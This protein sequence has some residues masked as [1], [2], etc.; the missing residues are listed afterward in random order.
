VTYT[1]T[2]RNVSDVLVTI[3]NVVDDRFG[4]LDDSGGNGCFDVPINLAPGASTF[5]QF[6]GTVSG[7]AGTTHVNVVTATG[8]DA[9]D[10]P[11][12]GSDDARVEITPRLIDLVIDK[13]ATSPTPLNGTV[14]YTL[15]VT[16]RGPD[17]A[18]NVQLAD[19]A[20]A[21]VQYQSASTSQGTCAVTPALVTCNLGTIA[22]GQVVTVTVTG[23]ATATGTHVNTATVSG[24]GGRETNPADN[25]DS[26]QTVVPA[27][28]RPPTK[29]TKPSK[30]K[31]PAVEADVCLALTVSPSSVTADGK[32]DRVRTLVTAGTKRMKGVRVVIRGVGIAKT[33]RTNERGVAV[34]TINPRRAGIITITAQE[35]NRQICG[36]K[37][38]GAVGV[39]LPPVTG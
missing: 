38:I 3:E 17:Q 37:R 36:P 2:I 22:P 8:K 26:A 11:V 20:P 35:R 23:R 33:G 15:T 5:C 34:V 4:D 16:N 12:S 19:P 30:P 28:L 18:T 10:N 21:G 29:P 31:P 27:P 14:T 1:V 7:A 9:F 13:T 25:T 24:Q 39:F 6:T 32:P